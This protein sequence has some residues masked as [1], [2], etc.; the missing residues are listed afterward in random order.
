MTF[1]WH[2]H[3]WQD[4]PYLG[5]RVPP[6]QKLISTSKWVC[7]PSYMLLSQNERFCHLTAVSTIASQ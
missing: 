7:V 5:S 4:R 6:Y 1:F 2:A 3:N